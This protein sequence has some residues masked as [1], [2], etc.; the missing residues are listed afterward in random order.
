MPA[1]RVLPADSDGVLPRA[2]T[3]TEAIVAG[4]WARELGMADIGL[5]DDLID[6]GANS[7]Q[8][9]AILGA[10]E[11]IFG[12]T[13]PTRLLFEE[14][15][16]ADLAAWIDRGRGATTGASAPVR[17]QV[18]AGQAPVFAVPGGRGDESQIFRLGQLARAADSCWPVY[19]FPGD[20]PVPLST[21][22]TE[23][24]EAAAALQVAAVR[25]IQP[26]GPY[27]LF[28][29]CIGGLFGWEMAR[30]L[31]ATGETVTLFMADTRN[32]SAQ[33]KDVFRGLVREATTRDE[34]RHH[35]RV[36]REWRTRQSAAGLSWQRPLGESRKHR[37]NI[38][39]AY[40]PGPIAA[41]VTLVVNEFWHRVDPTLGWADL[42]GDRLR[43]I[44]VSGH[45]GPEWNLP[46]IAAALRAWLQEID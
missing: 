28:G 21:P 5:G 35:R 1:E 23:W 39:R 20:V 34:I 43:V 38:V 10:L 7:L 45:H 25:A 27:R 31:E 26:Q 9:A 11:T 8:G 14:P 36:R 16:V 44:P 18:G 22:A 29:Y 3:P 32:L 6:L 4:V 41:N 12:L 19:A 15:T 2:S 17:I 42:L 40:T 33:E 13:M 30:Q 37:V 46:E 24:V